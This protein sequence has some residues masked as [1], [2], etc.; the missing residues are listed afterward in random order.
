MRRPMMN[1]GSELALLEAGLRRQL[2]E[3]LKRMAATADIG[4]IT[5]LARIRNDYRRK[6]RV[7]GA[8]VDIRTRAKWGG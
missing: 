6:Q 3:D 2:A 4:T 5:K 1:F 7:P 8:V